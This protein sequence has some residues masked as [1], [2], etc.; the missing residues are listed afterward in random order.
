MPHK[1]HLTRARLP[2]HYLHYMGLLD[3]AV[4]IGPSGSSEG[5]EDSEG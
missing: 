3:S 5:S 1:G 2:T 4:G